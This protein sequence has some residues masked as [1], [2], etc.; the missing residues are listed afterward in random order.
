M[1]RVKECMYGSG[2]EKLKFFEGVGGEVDVG[3]GVV[4]GVDLR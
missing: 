4:G 3:V 1:K 2:F